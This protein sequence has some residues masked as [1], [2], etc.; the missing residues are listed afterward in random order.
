MENITIIS[1][2]SWGSDMS[3]DCNDLTNNGL[4]FIFTGYVLPLL[5]PN[6]RGY[7]YEKLLFMKNMGNIAGKAVSVT[8]Y[9][10]TNIQKLSKNGEMVDFIDRLCQKKNKHILTNQLINLAWSFSG[11]TDNGNKENREETWKKLLKE[12]DRI[13]EL[14]ILDKTTK[15]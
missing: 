9:G 6:V 12:V 8:E 4:Y 2:N 3:I 10:F 14:N 13:H 15:P 11:D 7:L 1:E 5:S